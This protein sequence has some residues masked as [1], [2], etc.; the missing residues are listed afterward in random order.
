MGWFDRLT[1]RPPAKA[2]NLKRNDLCW[3]DSGKKYKRCH[4]A[5]DS[6]YFAAKRDEEHAAS[7][8]RYG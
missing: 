5:A 2:R 6:R 4:Q 3:C 7:C 1:G 8:N